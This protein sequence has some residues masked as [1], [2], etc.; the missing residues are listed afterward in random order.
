MKVSL[1]FIFVLMFI[2]LSGQII[3]DSNSIKGIRYFKTYPTKRFEIKTKDSYVKLKNIKIDS[4][5]ILGFDSIDFVE[6]VKTKIPNKKDGH[7][8]RNIL[9]WS[10]INAVIKHDTIE[11]DIINQYYT[12]S[13]FRD[14]I[15]LCL[16]GKICAK[17]YNI[18]THLF[19][20]EIIRGKFPLT[21][22]KGLYYYTLNDNLF[23]F[24]RFIKHRM[25][26]F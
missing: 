10:K 24:F 16:E 8:Y 6:Y 1:I 12:S 19:Y 15:T 5:F 11:M 13:L 26:C 20:K 9:D 18:H 4:S 3:Q 17:L 22:S 7:A 2:N 14:F 23:V 21:Y 25:I